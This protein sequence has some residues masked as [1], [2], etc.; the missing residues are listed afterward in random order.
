[1][2]SGPLPGL[3]RVLGNHTR[4]RGCMR[5]VDQA[6]EAMP[7]ICVQRLWTRCVSYVRP[8]S[9][10]CFSPLQRPASCPRESDFFVQRNQLD[11]PEPEEIVRAGID[12]DCG[13]AWGESFRATEPDVIEGSHIDNVCI[14]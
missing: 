6:V 8:G 2:G 4:S 5:S 14:R 12:R 9:I 3:V 11:A 13:F 1:M 7:F 10:D